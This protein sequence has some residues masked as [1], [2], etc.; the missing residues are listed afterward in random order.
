M[1]YTIIYK[2]IQDH[3]KHPELLAQDLISNPQDQR[4]VVSQ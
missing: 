3:A 2:D 4:P 1:V